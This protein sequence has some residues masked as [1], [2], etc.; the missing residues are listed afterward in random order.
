[1]RLSSCAWLIALAGRAYTY[2]GT[3][4]QDNSRS[5]AVQSTPS[6]RSCMLETSHWTHHH[7]SKRRSLRHATSILTCMKRVY[8]RK[9]M[10]RSQSSEPEAEESSPPLA[11][12]SVA[13]A[14]TLPLLPC[15]D[16][17]F[18]SL[19]KSLSRNLRCSTLGKLRMHS[20]RLMA[21]TH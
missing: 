8:I 11:L 2:H 16:D 14:G 7:L 3:C 9:C 15:L 1:M 12:A 4:F 5:S 18:V 20:F 17:L 19:L 6:F 13:A 10:G 21:P